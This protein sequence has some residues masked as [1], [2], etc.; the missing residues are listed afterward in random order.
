MDA[1]ILIWLGKTV[2]LR[3]GSFFVVIFRAVGIIRSVALYVTTFGIIFVDV[4][5]VIL[6]SWVKSVWLEEYADTGN[7]IAAL[8]EVSRMSCTV[9]PF[10]VAIPSN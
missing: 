3:F 1:L 9:R 7:T 4:D 6:D 10:C 5:G 2:F 8:S